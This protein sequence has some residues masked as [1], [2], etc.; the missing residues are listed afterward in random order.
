MKSTKTV[1]VL[2]SAATLT[3]TALVAG[4]EPSRTTSRTVVAP[5]A[6][7]ATTRDS[8]PPAP[9][10]PASQP[11]VAVVNGQAITLQELQKPLID[12]YGLNVLLNLVQLEL[13]KQEAAA[14]KVSITPADIE[15]ERDLTI[16]KMFK[17]ADKKDYDHLLDQFL[18]Q[19]RISRP[20]FDI[21]IET[22]AYLRKIAEPML[23]GKITE[24]SLQ[25]AFRTLYGENVQI[26]DIQV[27]NL[28]EVATIRRRLAAGEPFE[29]V[30]R[31]MSRDP[32]TKAQGGLLPPFS[33][34]I[35]GLSQAFKDAAFALKE[36]G[37]VSDPIQT[38][39]EFHVIQLV[40]K[41]APKAVKFEDV[42]ESVRDELYDRLMQATVAQ[43]RRELARK[44]MQTMVIEDPVLKKQFDDKLGKQR[45]EA[46]QQEK[47]RLEIEQ[48]R[49]ALS[50]RQ[51]IPVPSTKPATTPG[52]EARERPP[53]TKSGQ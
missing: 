49:K 46:Q 5:P 3:A 17:D 16:E 25:E 1:P 44:T 7:V 18:A 51:T 45:A 4:C 24:E 15:R 21:V 11:A 41:I 30:A 20:E 50:E 26:R 29:K 6:A 37:E 13:A 38:G 52:T 19:Q 10:A 40:R 2:L 47:A 42:K 53:A 43:L 31:E 14:A 12:A 8:T 36:P 39:D 35:T 23:K 28:Q 22:N 34:E 32:R 27:A 33:R 48:Q 9:A